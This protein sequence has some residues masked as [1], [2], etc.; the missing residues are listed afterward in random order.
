[1]CYVDRCLSFCTFSFCHCV[2]CSFSIYGFWLPLWYLQTLLTKSNTKVVETG[3][4]VIPS[5]YLTAHFHTLIIPDCSLS[6]PQHTWLLT[7]MPST[8]LTAHFHALNIP[9]HSLSYPQHTWLLTFMP[10]TYLTAHFHT[11]IIPD[12]SLSYPQHTWPLTFIPSSYLTA[13]FHGFSQAFQ[14]GKGGG[15]NLVLWVHELYWYL[16][17]YFGK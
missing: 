2:V 11:L 16:M 9:D 3:T 10:S 15:V 8:Y 1:M 13:H 17:A 14:W 7:F 4:K 5:S 6:C 12:R